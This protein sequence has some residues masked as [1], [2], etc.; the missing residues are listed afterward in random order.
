M[1]GEGIIGIVVLV[2]GLGIAALGIYLHAMKR[3]SD[4]KIFPY[5]LTWLLGVL[6]VVAGA[7]MIYTGAEG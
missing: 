1:G 3:A 6:M 4:K 2:L 7:I 5:V